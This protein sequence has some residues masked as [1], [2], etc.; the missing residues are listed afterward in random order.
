MIKDIT[1]TLP[2]IAAELADLPHVPVS[3]LVPFQGELK[4]LSEREYNKLKK[5]ITENGLIVPFFVWSETGKLLD[6]H[7]RLRVFTREGWVMDVPVVY[8]SAV[9]E[10]DAKR[11][12]LVISSQYGRVTQ[13]GWD[14]FTFD[15]PEPWIQ[16]TVQFDAL[17]F[18]FD[19]ELEGM[20]TTADNSEGESKQSTNFIDL[21][22]PEGV[23]DAIW[24]SDNE[25]GIPMLDITRQADAFDLPIETW[26]A[27]ARGTKAG[28]LHFY[29][30]DYRFSAVWTDPTRPLESGC[31]NIVEPNY[32]VYDQ[33]PRAIAL[34]ATY[35]K[36]WLA[37]Y[38]QSLGVRI[39]VD[40]NVARPYDDINLL[41]VPKGWRAY[42]TRGYSNRLQALAEE[43]EITKSHAGDSVLFMVYG[44]GLDV[45]TWCEDRAI[46]G[47]VWVAE[48]MDRAKGRYLDALG[49]AVD[50]EE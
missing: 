12:L 22:L 40:L 37:R 34:W 33:V 24:P 29:T 50:E 10:L 31:I 39:F 9:D 47:V 48:D 1:A 30:E 2:H 23:P 4:E 8:V 46:D 42:A 28:T 41:G 32:S 20:G 6:G 25:W 38:W 35:R 21:P 26:G 27:K 36:R 11:K 16:E 13:E 18:V 14:A 7:Q 17:P 45:K 3:A 19:F 43:L 44:G 5:S 49:S 15:I